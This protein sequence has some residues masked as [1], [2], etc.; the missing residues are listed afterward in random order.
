MIV[1]GVSCL[2]SKV[3]LVRTCQGDSRRLYRILY[4][5]AGRFLYRGLPDSYRAEV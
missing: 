3:P 1:K 5:D 4:S 2:D